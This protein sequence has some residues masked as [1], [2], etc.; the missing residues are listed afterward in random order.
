MMGQVDHGVVRLRLRPSWALV[1]ALFFSVSV[2]FSRCCCAQQWQVLGK[3]FVGEWASCHY[4]ACYIFYGASLICAARSVS[5][6][7]EPGIRCQPDPKIYNLHVHMKKNQ[8]KLILHQL[9]L[10]KYKNNLNIF[11]LFILTF[12]L[13]E[14]NVNIIVLSKYQ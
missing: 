13:Q 2:V 9:N 6:G 3:G 12:K 10:D 4:A 5:S 8:S 7:L 14:Q 1:E 11:V